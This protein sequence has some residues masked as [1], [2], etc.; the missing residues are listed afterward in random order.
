MSAC[1][2]RNPHAPHGG[3][4]VSIIKPVFKI[5]TFADRDNV[6]SAVIP[7]IEPLLIFC[8]IEKV[9]FESDEGFGCLGLVDAAHATIILFH[10]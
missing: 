6:K 10:I 2:P 3:V 4:V 9:C 7:Q 5:V 1:Q 8:V